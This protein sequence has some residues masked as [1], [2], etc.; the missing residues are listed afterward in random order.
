MWLRQHALFIRAPA[1]AGPP[2]PQLP[3]AAQTAQLCKEGRTPSFCLAHRSLRKLK[4]QIP[5]QPGGI[6]RQEGE[7]A[8]LHA[9]SHTMAGRAPAGQPDPLRPG[10]WRPPKKAH[11]HPLPLAGSS[12]QPARGASTSGHSASSCFLA[13]VTARAARPCTAGAGSHAPLWEVAS[14]AG[15]THRVQ[16]T[17]RAPPTRG[18]CLGTFS[19]GQRHRKQSTSSRLTQS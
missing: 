8:L 18:T 17:G 4:Q 14:R 5:R 1:G 11:V 2:S 10:R 15:S 19:K 7:L 3:P 9:A 12:A 6:P 13:T 16:R